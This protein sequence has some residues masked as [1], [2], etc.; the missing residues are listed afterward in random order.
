V[1]RSMVRRVE[2][3]AL[4]LM[5]DILSTYYK[6][7]LSAT[8]HKFIVSGHM[9]ILTFFLVWVCGTRV[10]NLSAP[11]SYTLY[12]VSCCQHHHIN[13][14]YNINASQFLTKSGEIQRSIIAPLLG[15]GRNPNYLL[16]LLIGQSS[17]D[18]T[19]K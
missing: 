19:G 6:C 13:H 18:R 7:T 10:Q 17:S 15:N 8:T 1:R 11:F 16:P 5:E 14:L 3:G 2:R 12:S 4:D 9:L